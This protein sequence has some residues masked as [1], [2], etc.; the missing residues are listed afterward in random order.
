MV[1]RSL[2]AVVARDDPVATVRRLTQSGFYDIET[3][4][5]F[6]LLA[7]PDPTGE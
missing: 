5:N 2:L 3:N 6:V 1:R 4:E 7:R